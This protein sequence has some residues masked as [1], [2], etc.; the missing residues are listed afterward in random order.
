M[1][2]NIKLHDKDREIERLKRME[3]DYKSSLN[4]KNKLIGLLE[5]RVEYLENKLAAQHKPSTNQITQTFNH[6]KV[7][8]S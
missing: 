2:N 7:L 6:L 1:S 8:H 5:H 3:I 4:T